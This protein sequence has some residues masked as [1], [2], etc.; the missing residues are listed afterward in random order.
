MTDPY[1]DQVSLLLHFDG[2]H[3][4]TTFTD[5]SPR[6]KSAL[7]VGEAALTTAQMRFGSAC[8][9]LSG[10]Y[11]DIPTSAD[12]GFGTG[13]YTIELWVKTVQNGSYTLLRIRNGGG[14]IDLDLGVV[15]FSTGAVS[16]EGSIPVNDGQ[17]HHIAVTR[18]PDY[19]RLFVDGIQEQ[20]DSTLWEVFP[21][22]DITL[23]ALIEEDEPVRHFIG[24]VDELRITKGVARYTAAF[25]PPT[26]PFP[27]TP[28]QTVTVAAAA[29]SLLSQPAV[30]VT[31]EGA[32]PSPTGFLAAP[33]RP[34][35]FGL[36]SVEL[37]MPPGGI[38]LQ[39]ASLRP[40]R[41]GRP[42][43]QSHLQAGSV[44]SLVSARFGTP[45]C[46]VAMP[47]ASMR[48]GAFGVPSLGARAPALPL[49]PTRFGTPRLGLQFQAAPCSGPRFGVPR[50]LL[51]GVSLQAE[52]LAPVR[53]GVPAL[54]GI[55]LRARPLRS[56]RFG[57][58]AANR[59]S[60]C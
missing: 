28:S 5:S 36:A 43:L 18:G 21:P 3:G 44:Q 37:G 59:E 57:R 19:V 54:G 58:P 8:L 12:F 40:V 33:L 14:Q 20:Q 34:V 13:E 31:T 39:A 49:R 16:L 60:A 50:V 22:S 42:A 24:Q 48:A 29:P 45:R 17:W 56:V 51:A 27:P 47:A 38:A 25:T 30:V 23:G 53:F 11:V 1:Y 41:F 7:A 35:R 52:S 2:T 4:S 32:T 46:A 6:A 10:G 26:G 15:M 55:A 9:S